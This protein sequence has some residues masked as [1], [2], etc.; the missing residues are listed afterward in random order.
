[1]SAAYGLEPRAVFGDAP[2]GLV[3]LL[4]RQLLFIP[5]GIILSHRML[6]SSRS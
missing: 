6:I 4:V 2:G 3:L 1:M 5:L